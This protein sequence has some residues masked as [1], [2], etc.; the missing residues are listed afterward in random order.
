MSKSQNVAIGEI[1]ETGLEKRKREAEE[2]TSI[3][4]PLYLRA[5]GLEQNSSLKI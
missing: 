4:V 2:S 3:E 5:A 1:T